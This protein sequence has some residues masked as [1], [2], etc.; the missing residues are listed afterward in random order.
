[1]L[2][3][4]KMECPTPDMNVTLPDN[5]TVLNYTLGFKMDG[6][7]NFTDLEVGGTNSHTLRIC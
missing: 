1:M 3:D 5:S 4:V 2:S 6:V 7:P